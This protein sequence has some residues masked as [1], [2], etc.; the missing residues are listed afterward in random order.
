[1]AAIRIE[2]GGRDQYPQ[3]Q[4]WRPS[5][6][7]TDTYIRVNVTELDMSTAVSPYI[8]IGVFDPPLRFVAGDIP[9]VYSPHFSDN[10]LMMMVLNGLGP[11]NYVF[12]S[13]S[14]DVSMIQ[15]SIFSSEKA[16]PL[17]SLGVGKCTSMWHAKFGF[18]II[19]TAVRD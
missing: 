14:L 15:T 18:S 8:H 19:F 3:F 7:L 9:G 6:N 1:M 10:V 16:L 12:N 13:S 11:L 5:S 4:I 2:G 17:I